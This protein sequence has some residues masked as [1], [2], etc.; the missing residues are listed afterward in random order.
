VDIATFQAYGFFFFTVFMVVLLY[1][2][3][4][5]LY[6]SQKEG[7]RDFEKYSNLALHDEVTDQP[8]DVIL[9][10]DETKK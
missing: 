8:I 7:K 10:D 9:K 1:T 4:Y 5:H 2:Y 6:S 3:I